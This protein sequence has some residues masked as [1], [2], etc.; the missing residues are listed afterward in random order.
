MRLHEA[1]VAVNES[2]EPVGGVKPD[3]MKKSKSELLD[4]AADAGITSV[5]ESNTK[6]EI[7]NAITD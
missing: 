1:T 3:L 6:A 5:S 7:V 4:M 2:A